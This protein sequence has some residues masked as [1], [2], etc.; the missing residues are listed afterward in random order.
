VKILALL[1]LYL[2]VSCVLVSAQTNRTNDNAANL[3]SRVQQT[4]ASQLDSTLPRMPLDRWLRSQVGSDTTINWAVRTADISIQRYPWIEADVSIQGRPEI[5]II[6][7][8]IAAAKRPTF[9][10]LELIEAGGI[11]EWPRLC[12]LPEA[13]KRAK[14]GSR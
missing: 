8:M 14:D 9:H 10:S 11:A 3:I 13:L 5:V 2:A 1:A 7:I 6:V 4:P 12:F